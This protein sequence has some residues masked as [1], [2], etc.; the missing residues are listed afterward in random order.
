MVGMLGTR[1]DE[2]AEP[3]FCKAMKTNTHEMIEQFQ[4]RSSELVT[5]G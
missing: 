4:M 1:K 3:H 5:M 2:V